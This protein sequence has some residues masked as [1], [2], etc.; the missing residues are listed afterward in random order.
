[1]SD[2]LEIMG[3]VAGIG[4]LA[5]GVFLFLFRDLIRRTAVGTLG[6]RLTYRVLRQF[7]FYVWSVAIIGLV[8]WF[9]SDTISS[10]GAVVLKWIVGDVNVNVQR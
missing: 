7:M 2:V 1:M 9:G 5:L 10:N 6:P 3:K 4:G 8:L